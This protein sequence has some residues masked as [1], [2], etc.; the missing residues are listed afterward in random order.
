MFYGDQTRWFIGNVVDVNDPLQMGRIRVRIDGIHT[1]DE[2]EI[3]DYGLPWAQV[4]IPVNE[5]GTNGTGNVTGIR[6]NAR[7]F[8]IF[9][10]GQNSQSP[11]V[12]GSIPKYETDADGTRSTTQRARGTDTLVDADGNSKQPNNVIGEPDDPYAAVYPDNSV[13]ATPSGHMIELDDTEGA[14]RIHIFHRSGSFVEFHPNGDVVTHHKNGFKAVAGNDKIH[15][16]GNFELFV[17]GDMK[18]TVKGNVIEDFKKSQTTNVKDNVV[19]DTD[20]GKIYLN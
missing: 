2:Q 9:L 5:G 11:L 13:H 3:P 18:V 6:P 10:D 20:D 14:E 8:G 17:D 12:V 15:V 7:V 4:V 19:I 1:D 16:T